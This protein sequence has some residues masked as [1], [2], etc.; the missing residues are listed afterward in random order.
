[1]HAYD[2]T[3]WTCHP[4][5][6]LLRLTRYLWA[7]QW[8]H[9]FPTCPLTHPVAVMQRR[10]RRLFLMPLGSTVLQLATRCCSDNRTHGTEYRLGLCAKREHSAELGFR[11]IAGS[12]GGPLDRVPAVYRYQR[13]LRSYPTRRSAILHDCVSSRPHHRRTP[14]P[15]SPARQL[16]PAG[17]YRRFNEI[18]PLS[19]R[20]CRLL[21]VLLGFVVPPC[22][23]MMLLPCR[24]GM[25][26]PCRIVMLPP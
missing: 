4:A 8:R 15:A 12:Y 13:D 9:M 1:M 25:P 7:C 10:H 18:N 19:A 17:R 21:F 14:S 24:V 2:V 11:I 20:C 3:A 23:I 16:H 26:P 6:G 5:C 22:R